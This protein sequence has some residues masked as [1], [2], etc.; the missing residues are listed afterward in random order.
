MKPVYF[1][2]T[3]SANMAPTTPTLPPP[4]LKLNDKLMGITTVSPKHCTTHHTFQCN[5]ILLYMWILK[6]LYI[7]KHTEINNIYKIGTFVFIAK[8]IYLKK[9]KFH[10][11]WMPLLSPTV[12][13]QTL[14]LC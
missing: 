5:F 4:S 12:K 9:R 11:Y 6:F 10:L 8:R 1:A 3:R 7:R 2:Q 13:I 14:P